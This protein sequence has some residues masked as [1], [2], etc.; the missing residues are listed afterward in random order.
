M[1]KAEIP[2]DPSLRWEWI[3]YQL[4]AK[5]TSL[6]KLA[7]ELGVSGPAVKNVKRTA[8]PRMEREIAKALCMETHDLWPERWD[9]DGN[10]HRL[11]PNRREASSG[12]QQKNNPAYDLGHR[13]SSKEA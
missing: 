10:P 2:L 6:A 4:R 7:R 5:G 11:R 8:Y 3:K 1:N 13:K 12:E 9:I